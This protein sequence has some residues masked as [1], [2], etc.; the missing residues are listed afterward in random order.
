M[1]VQLWRIP[2][3]NSE[4]PKG[5]RSRKRA[6]FD[7][8]N[9]TSPRLGGRLPHTAQHRRLSRPKVALSLQKYLYLDE[10]SRDLGQNI[11]SL[12][13]SSLLGPFQNA[14]ALPGAKTARCHL[15]FVRF[16]RDSA[17]SA[18]FDQKVH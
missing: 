16:H 8:I 11:Q 18:A 5:S 7:V 13:E 1:G 3:I 6:F 15:R 10:R 9:L 12:F 2:S 4:I 14:R 17:N